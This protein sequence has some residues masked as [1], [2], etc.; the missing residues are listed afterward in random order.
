MV[1][2]TNKLFSGLG[3]QVNAVPLQLTVGPVIDTYPQFVAI[4]AWRYM[5]KTVSAADPA[6]LAH[7]S[8]VDIK[9]SA[10]SIGQCCQS[11]CTC[12]TDICS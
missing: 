7:D 3:A 1:C 6:D 5:S 12:F 8:E 2:T 10:A 4:G 9:Q 11:V